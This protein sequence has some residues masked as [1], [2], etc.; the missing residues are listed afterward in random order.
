MG[1]EFVERVFL[2]PDGTT[3]VRRI[4]VKEVSL[5]EYNE[6]QVEW[7]EVHR[8][9]M[10]CREGHGISFNDACISWVKNGYSEYFRQQFKLKEN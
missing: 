5:K 2:Y 10:S 8:Y 4:E 6:I 7:I 1:K 9:F 3:E